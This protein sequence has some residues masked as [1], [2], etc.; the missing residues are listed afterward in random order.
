MAINIANRS[1][2]QVESGSNSDTY[3]TTV[4]EN[5]SNDSVL[6]VYPWTE[7]NPKQQRVDGLLT[8]DLSTTPPVSISEGLISVGFTRSKAVGSMEAVYA[9]YANADAIREGNWVV[10]KTSAKGK[11]TNPLKEGIVR[12]IGQIFNVNSNYVKD[13]NGKLTSTYK[14][15]VREWS[16]ILYCPVRYDPYVNAGQSTAAVVQNVTQDTYP[17]GSPPSLINIPYLNSRSKDLK[18]NMKQEQFSLVPINLAAN[19]NKITEPKD[20]AAIMQELFIRY[21]QPFTYVSGILALISNMNKSSESLSSVFS[22]QDCQPLVDSLNYHYKIV[23]RSASIPTQ[24]VKDHL[25]PSSDIGGYDPSSPLSTGFLWYVSGVQKWD[26]NKSAYDPRTG[27]YNLRDFTGSGMSSLVYSPKEAFRPGTLMDPKVISM[28]ASA[29]EVISGMC[30]PTA[31]DFYTDLWYTEAE[32]GA[33]MAAPVLVVRDNPFSIKAYRK[34]FTQT[35]NSKYKWTMFDDLP[36]L[37]IR[38]SSVLSI[39]TTRNILESVNYVRVVPNTMGVM[40]QQTQAA[41]TFGGTAVI[42]SQQYRFGGKEM[43]VT[44]YCGL[45]TPSQEGSDQGATYDPDWFTELRNRIVEWNSN[46]HVWF[47]MTVTIKDSDYPLT[48]GD[49]IRIPLG[50]DRPILIGHLDAVDFRI[51]NE[52][53]G[54]VTNSVV[55]S[56]SRVGMQDPSDGSDFNGQVVPLPPSASIRLPFLTTDDPSGL[57]LMVQ[58]ETPNK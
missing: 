55:L 54:L 57:S 3:A 34:L 14:V 26:Q 22:L 31:Y 53:S 23:A 6:I 28:G 48:V 17:G 56:I 45:V 24:L 43:V 1:L 50:K 15:Y 44:S 8:V 20:S 39:N 36:Q 18:G 38:S 47:K 37:T 2:N 27:L 25:Y 32:N 58:P 12:F 29:I 16:H 13:G 4:T 40:D 33:I 41:A 10:F 49:N 46:N 42:P 19:E 35:N 21:R 11:I 30:E 51:K 7:P 52:D 5:L 9:G